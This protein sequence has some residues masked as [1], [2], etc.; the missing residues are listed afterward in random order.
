MREA[1][2]KQHTTGLLAAAPAAVLLLGGCSDAGHRI[3][4]Q[5]PQPGLSEVEVLDEPRTYQGP[6]TAVLQDAAIEPI[7]EYPEQSLPTTVT[8]YG[9]DGAEQQ[10]QITETSRVVARDMS[11]SIAARIWAL[12][13]SDSLVGVDQSTTFPGTEDIETVTSGGHT[14]NAEAIIGLERDVVITDG[15]IGPRDVVEQLSDVGI[16][17]VFVENTPSF[18]GAEELARQVAAVYGAP[19]VGQ[20]LAEQISADI[21]AK[22]KEISALVPEHQDDQVRMLFLYLRGNVGVYYMFGSESGADD[23]I[24]ALGA[25]RY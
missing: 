17:V 7:T 13:F 10:L 4:A 22:V 21:N 14:V 24:S 5:A 1:T 11:G 12:G 18:E 3:T 19:A 23:L 9:Q 6:S 2:M 16:T 15:S 8:S 20:Q 25:R